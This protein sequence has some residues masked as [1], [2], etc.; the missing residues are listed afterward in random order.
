MWWRIASLAAFAVTAQARCP[1]TPTYS[2]CEMVFELNDAEAAEHANPYLSVQ[3]HAE[4]RSPEAKTFLMNG[5]WDGGRR[6]VVRF[7]PVLAGRWDYRI[8]SNIGRF[9][10][11]IGSFHATE[12]DSKG[13]VIVNNLRH[14]SYTEKGVKP[15]PHLWMGDTCYRFAVIDRAL[16]E[17]LVDAR[18]AQKFNHLRGLVMGNFP[19][20]DGVFR[21]ADTPNTDY[22]RT[23]DE[24]VGYLHRRGVT[25]DLIFAGDENHLVKVFPTW[26]QRARYIRYVVSR[27]GAFNVTWQGVQEF[28]EYAEARALLKEIGETIRKSDPYNHPRS[29]HTTATSAPLLPDGWMDY[30][31]YQSSDIALGAIE[32]QLY[33][34]P[35]VNTE[36]GYENSGAGASHPHH[37]DADTFRKRLWNASM[38]GQYPTYGN[39]GTYGGR[40]FEPAAQYLDSPGARQMAHWFD[41][42][43]NTRHWELEPYFDVDGGRALALPGVEYIVYIETP[44]PVDIV[45]EKKTY[46]VYWFNPATGESVQ[47]K[48]GKEFKGE[49]FTGQ[50]PTMDHDWV[51]HLSRDDR[52]RSMANSFYFESRRVP[53]QEVELDPKRRPYEIVAPPG[54]EVP[55]GKP[56]PYEAKVTRET[57]AS[58]RMLFLW[59][60]DVAGGGQGYRVVATGAKGELTIPE[61]IVVRMPA[62]VNLRLLGM[63]LLGKVYS[64]NR[65][66][67]LTR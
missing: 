42:F 56:A 40:E 23:L 53:I 12:S 50:P 3:L 18:V 14:F 34:A 24:R 52:K 54:G 44:G 6:M 19:G 49:R 37:V 36:F 31:A 41:F 33:A 58:S 38:N 26:Q 67:K 7:S 66:Y 15:Y 63:N 22:F 11:E 5:F 21:D 4:F 10:G 39:T 35:Q 16:F 57:R 47:I 64:E 29:T 20:L 2:P 28:E 30:I 60:A 13:F 27:Y 65:V 62:N 43:S 25:A 55:V 51:L 32:H 17:K 46:Q 9:N 1:D 48:K 61:S 59:T 8:T 45:I